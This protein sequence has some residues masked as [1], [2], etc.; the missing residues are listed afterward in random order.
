MEI[1][2]GGT[3]KEYIAEQKKISED[4]ANRILLQ[5]M[6]AYSILADKGI[7]HRDLKPDNIIFSQSPSNDELLPKIIDFGYCEVEG[8]S[9]P[10]MFYNVGSPRYMSP[11]AFMSNIYSQKS[12]IWG[13]GI[14]YYEMLTG[15][16][17][18]KGKEPKECFKQIKEK[19]IPI[20]A[21]LDANSKKLLQMMLMYD[22]Q[23]RHTCQ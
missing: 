20:P 18:D 5:L 17:F 4:K 21:S 1:L 14:I 12:D 11:E 23:K 8:I 10:N 7:V 13:L 2:E 3:L 6:E 16:N 19:G 22:P 15:T 9:K